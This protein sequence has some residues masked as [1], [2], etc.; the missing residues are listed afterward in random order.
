MRQGEVYVREKPA[1]IITETD[2]QEYI[3]QYY[4]EYV[5]DADNEPV[6]LTMPIRKEPYTSKVLFPY[7]FSILSEGENR[8]TQADIYHLDPN[9]DFGI[10]LATAG[11]DTIGAVT[12]KPLKK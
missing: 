8:K 5:A 10:M 1:G 2:A 7:F 9:D 4:P 11:N 12:V 6:S 3:F